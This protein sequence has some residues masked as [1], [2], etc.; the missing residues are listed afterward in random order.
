MEG[1][2]KAGGGA[3]GDGDPRNYWAAGWSGLDV[4]HRGLGNSYTQ[5]TQ[6][7]NCTDIVL[8]IWDIKERLL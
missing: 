3:Q 8:F 7:Y 2:W 5:V 1:P 4:G 6:L